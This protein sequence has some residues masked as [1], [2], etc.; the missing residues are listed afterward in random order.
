M[1]ECSIEGETC[2]FKCSGWDGSDY[3]K[4]LHDTV[5]DIPCDLCREDAVPNMS[6]FHDF[7]NVGLGKDPYDAAN[8]KKFAKKVQCAYETCKADGRCT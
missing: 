5:K 2:G 4:K 7:V 8:F 3:W 6:G 1:T